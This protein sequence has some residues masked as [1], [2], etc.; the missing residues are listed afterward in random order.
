MKKNGKCVQV[1][2]FGIRGYFEISVFEM[3]SVHCIFPQNCISYK[4]VWLLELLFYDTKIP[5]FIS[6]IIYIK[7]CIVER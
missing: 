2:F 3:K 6:V 1:I 5:T 4:Y 7:L